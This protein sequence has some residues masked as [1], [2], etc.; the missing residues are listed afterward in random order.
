MSLISGDSFEAPLIDAKRLPGLLPPGF[1][2][3]ASTLHGFRRFL[4][5]ALA[6]EAADEAAADDGRGPTAAAADAVADRG[7]APLTCRS[8]QQGRESFTVEIALIFGSG[9]YALRLPV[10]VVRAPAL[11]SLS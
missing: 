3:G 6:A 1:P 4:A 9:D 5:D 7:P 2:A 8:Q 10:V 11:S